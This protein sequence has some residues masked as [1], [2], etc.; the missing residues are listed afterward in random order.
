MDKNQIAEEG[1]QSLAANSA[2]K[3]VISQPKKK[4]IKPIKDVCTV[5]GY[6]WATL[7]KL[8]KWRFYSYTPRIGAGGEDKPL[9]KSGEFGV[10]FRIGS[11][12]WVN[13]DALDAYMDYLTN[14]GSDE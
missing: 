7:K 6:E 8:Q 4:R 11:R 1:Q 10:F 2:P 3:V 9:H 5:P 12:V 13:L 14:G